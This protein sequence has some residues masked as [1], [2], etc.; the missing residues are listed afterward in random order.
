MGK[1]SGAHLLVRAMRRHGVER[2]FGL[3][4]DHVNSIFNACLDEGVGVVDTRHESGATHL[5]D[6]WARVTGR[7]G[8]SVVTG[9]PGH[10]NSLTGL[11]TAWMAAS[12]MIAISG[13]HEARLREQGPLQ[14]VDQLDMVRAITKWARVAED[15]RRL[16]HYFAIA[17]REA[18]SGRPGPVHLTIPSD[19]AEATVD[20]DAPLP[21]PY[22]FEP[23]AASQAAL[24]AAIGL[25][26]GAERPVVVAGSGVWWSRGWEALERFVE[27]AQL[28]CFTIGM[29]R[30]AVSDEHP[31]CLGYADPI[32][33]AAAREIKRADVVLLIGKRVDFRLAYGNLFG[34]DAAL[35][36]ID[37]HGPELGRN[38]AAQLPIQ[39]DA[40]VA[41]EQLAAAAERHGG[42]RQKAWVEELRRAR[43]AFVAASARDEASDAA[44]L[45]PLRIVKE[46]REAAGGDVTWVIDGGDFAQWAR[47]ALPARLPG[48]WVR[49]GAMGTLG[50][51]IPF[52]IAA[53]LAH[54]K[55]PVVVLTGD[56]GM[57][58]HAWE[59]HTALRF[60]APVVVVVGNDCGWGMERELQRAFYDRTVGTELGP[61]R[62]DRVVA[63]MGGHGEHVEKPAE[64]RPA[65]E[66]ALRAGRPACVDV[67]MR[68]VASPLTAANIARIK[69]R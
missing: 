60:E 21:E 67:A 26:H 40:R 5:A 22:R 41:L 2:I 48:H 30:G 27:A 56:G 44:P 43:R 14:E 3:C 29:A 45:H 46:V 17:Y 32:L 23:A 49:L 59:L 34:P 11:A 18:V 7:P 61:V 12:P 1:I 68:G 38:R 62:Y 13:M 69:A 37:V 52:G 65:L 35:I 42:W 54:P 19:V 55:E 33:N 50:A 36:Q 16:A 6:G 58:F 31:L 20:D 9:G 8:V 25:L 47:L 4:G 57:A 24:D 66:R 15:P 53:Q 10:T 39:A 63:A 64:L 28:P 51:S